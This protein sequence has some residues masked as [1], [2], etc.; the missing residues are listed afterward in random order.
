MR[1][2]ILGNNDCDS[3]LNLLTWLYEKNDVEEI[4]FIK[5]E[6]Q[7]KELA[8]RESP[9][10]VFLRLNKDKPMG[11]SLLDALHKNTE[12]MEVIFIS[13]VDD[14]ALEAYQTG[15]SGYLVEPI[16]RKKFESCF[17][18]LINSK[19]RVKKQ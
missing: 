6:L 3:Q 15:A 16:E 11:L 17:S 9:D 5:N 7:F 10:V 1:V 4:T 2:C 8:E 12:N 14:Y 18:K 13:D 19:I